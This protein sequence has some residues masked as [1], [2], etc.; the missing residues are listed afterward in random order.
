MSPKTCGKAVPGIYSCRCF[1]GGG[2]TA[3]LDVDSL[4]FGLEKCRKIRIYQTN[5]YS[6]GMCLGF[7]TVSSDLRHAEIGPFLVKRQE[8]GA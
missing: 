4:L 8:H 3:G 6:I 2:Q 5:M 7:L 1:L